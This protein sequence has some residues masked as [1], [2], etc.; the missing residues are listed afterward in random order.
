MAKRKK[1]QT[2]GSANKKKKVT[3]SLSVLQSPPVAQPAQSNGGDKP[4]R[5]VGLQLRS[6]AQDEVSKDAQS[7]ILSPRRT[8]QSGTVQTK[9]RK[10]KSKEINSVQR[11]PDQQ[12]QSPLLALPVE[13]REMIH[14]YAVLRDNPYDCPTG[15]GQHYY[16]GGKWRDPL[17]KTAAQPA[18]SRTCRLLRFE[19]LGLYYSRNA[20]MVYCPFTR[21]KIPV[22]WLP[23]TRKFQLD[24][25][26]TLVF[27][28]W[29]PLFLQLRLV[30]KEPGFELKS[31]VWGYNDLQWLDPSSN[32]LPDCYANMAKKYTRILKVQA[33]AM[34][35]KR[36]T[37][38]RSSIYA[39]KAKLCRR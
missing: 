22:Q 30:D 7:Q 13:I 4:H 19:T 12:L 17:L 28:C 23:S 6:E 38:N 8:R 35:Q 27:Q 20:F 18:I 9:L 26:R 21:D 31:K 32:R 5:N 11:T 39:M 14:E 24:H 15:P 2:G 1:P 34:L 36:K 25:V 37:F 3:A 29:G 16:H 33:E 10:L